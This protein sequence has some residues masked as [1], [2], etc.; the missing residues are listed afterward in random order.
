MQETLINYIK[1]E[2]AGDPGVALSAEDDLL[3][4]GLIDS[5]GIMRLI[6]FIEEEFE[7]AIPPQ[8][9]VIDN[10]ISVNAIAAYLEG[11]KAS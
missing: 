5:M 11:A 4:S 1:K 2:L 7:V 9:M 6:A 10:F 8:D 3:N